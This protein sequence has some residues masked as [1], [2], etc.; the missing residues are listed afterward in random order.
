MENSSPTSQGQ[1]S[2]LRDWIDPAR[3]YNIY[4]PA[5]R[6]PFVWGLAVYP[7]LVLFVLLTA[8]I[9]VIESVYTGANIGDYIGIGTWV[10]ML[11]WVAAAV[12]MTYRRLSYLGKSWGLVWLIVLPVVNLIFFLYLLIKSGPAARRQTD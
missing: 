5:G 3:I 11:V 9:I 12:C 6:L 10:F 2:H 8:F 1:G 4:L 7:F